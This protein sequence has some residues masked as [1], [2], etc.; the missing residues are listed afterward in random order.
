MFAGALTGAVCVVDGLLPL[1]AALE[2]TPATV[3]AAIAVPHHFQ[4]PWRR[5]QSCPREVTG[6]RLPGR[7]V[8][9]SNT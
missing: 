2:I 4:F 7:Q 3:K 1:S 9:T 8:R 5:H 6:F